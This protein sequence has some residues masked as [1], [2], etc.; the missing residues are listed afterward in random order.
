[1]LSVCGAQ[2][3]LPVEIKVSILDGCQSAED[4]RFMDI[5]D[6]TSLMGMII[7]RTSTVGN[8]SSSC[9]ALFH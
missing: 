5:H 6:F 8:D 7:A 1:M 2:I 9:P 4:I 3:N